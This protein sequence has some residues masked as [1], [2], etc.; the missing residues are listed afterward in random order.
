VRLAEQWSEILAGLPRGWE[1]VSLSLSLDDPGQAGRAGVVLG[2]AA[3]GRRDAGFRI[4]VVR[5]SRPVGTSAALFRR[6]LLRLDDE[7]IGGRL[8]MLSAGG[9]TDEERAA[10]AS[11]TVGGLAGQWQALVDGL[12]PDWSHLLAQLDLDSSD[13]V[14]RA[15]LLMVPTNPGRIAGSRS[16]RFRVARRVGY[17]ASAGMT[18]RCCERL[19]GERITGRLSLVQVVSDARPVAT[20]GPVWRIG[21]R[22]V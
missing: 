8:S 18:R 3:P 6:V 19:D 17:G 1:A 13:F 7:G 11:A 16:F 15:A 2:P 21:G 22:A 4:D 20:Q 9:A 10:A 5:E 12:P 14:E